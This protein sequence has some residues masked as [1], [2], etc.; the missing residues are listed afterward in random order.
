LITRLESYTKDAAQGEP[1]A[2][3]E[4]PAQDAHASEV[5]ARLVK[6]VTLGLC[7]SAYLALVLFDNVESP[8]L[9]IGL[10]VLV[11]YELVQPHMRNR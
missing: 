9:S 7:V 10:I 8:L 3:A 1:S 11:A 4:T 2:H 6:D 5:R